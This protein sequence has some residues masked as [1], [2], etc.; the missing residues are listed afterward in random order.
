MAKK[1]KV[2]PSVRRSQTN[3]MNASHANKKYFNRLWTTAPTCPLFLKKVDKKRPIPKGFKKRPLR[4]NRVISTHT[5]RAL[6]SQAGALVSQT[7]VREGAMLRCGE[8][9][10]DVKYPLLPSFTKAAMMAFEKQ[11]VAYCQ[12]CFERAIDMKESFVNQKGQ[13][14]HAKITTRCAQQGVDSANERI[15][16][17]ATFGPGSVK[18]MLASAKPATKPRKAPKA[19]KAQTTVAAEAADDSD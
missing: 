8:M 11:I 12:L 4:I 5:F 14:M 10:E 3:I 6:S 13:M 16:Q 17:Y 19:A 2:V 9:G 1:S 7:L 15:A 18:P